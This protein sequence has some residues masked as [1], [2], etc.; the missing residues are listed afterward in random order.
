[1][2]TRQDAVPTR[3]PIQVAAVESA[4]SPSPDPQLARHN[5]PLPRTVT[6]T[7]PGG[8]PHHLAVFTQQ[9]RMAVVV[10][11]SVLAARAA[12]NLTGDAVEALLPTLE[13][14][15]AAARRCTDQSGPV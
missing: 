11:T 6:Q 8:R 9:A 10:L 15:A 12:E 13:S 14:L 1:M 4:R 5:S 7:G 2:G 3:Q